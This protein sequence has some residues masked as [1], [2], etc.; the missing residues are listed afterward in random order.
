[1][2]KRLDP[3]RHGLILA[4]LVLIVGALWAAVLAVF[5]EPL[6]QRFEQQ[7]IAR[8]VK[9]D[10]HAAESLEHGEAPAAERMH[11]H[12]GSLAADAMQRLL[13]GH[14]HFMGLGALSAALLL[15]TA[16]TGLK[17]VWKKTLGWTFGIGALAYPSAWII[18]GFRTVRMGPQAAEASIMW[19]FAPAVGLLLASMTALLVVLLV[20]ACGWQRK[21]PLACFFATKAEEACD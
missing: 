13:R 3:I 16:F 11:L 2:Q 20:E 9:A 8:S 21:T 15:V 19:L 10:A 14:I 4:I 5:H 18:M 1:M 17:N 12:A 7:E 6:H